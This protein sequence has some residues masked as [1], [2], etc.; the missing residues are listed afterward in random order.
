MGR[1]QI[2]SEESESFFHQ[3]YIDM[4][5]FLLRERPVATTAITDAIKHFFRLRFVANHTVL[6]SHSGSTEY[7]T[8]VLVTTFN[9]KSVVAK[10]S[11]Q[12]TADEITALLAVESELGGVGASSA[13]GVMKNVVEDFLKLLMIRSKYRVMVFT[14]LPYSNEKNSIVN[15]LDTLRT[16]YSRTPGVAGGMLLVHLSGSRPRSTQVQ[17]HVTEDSIRGFL[18]SSNGSS[19][20][21][22][23]QDLESPGKGVGP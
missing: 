20:T 10:R 3:L 8:D 18:I 13:Y 16:L 14:S 19:I 1:L 23:S 12:V 17:A 6:C 9:P 15:R 22:I 11:L 21:E 7:L 5:G 4:R 2:S